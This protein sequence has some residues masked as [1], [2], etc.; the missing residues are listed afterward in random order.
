VEAVLAG[1]DAPELP[2]CNRKRMRLLAVSVEN[3]WDETV[4]AQA[5]RCGAAA[6]VA[7]LHLQLDALAGHI[8][9][10]L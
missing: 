5:A 2:F 8:G 4:S 1:E 3:T 10:L 7:G 6:P 9:P